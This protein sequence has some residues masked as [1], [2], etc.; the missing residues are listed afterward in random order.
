MGYLVVFDIDGTVA[1]AGGP[2]TA[3]QIQGLKEQGHSWGILSSRSPERSRQATDAMGLSPGFIR[4]CRVYQRAEELKA[5]REECPEYGRYI[6]VADAP[7]DREEAIKAGWAFIFA[8][9]FTPGA[10]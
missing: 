10:L 8:G 1:G 9:Q 7:Q 3:E 2:V 6:Y 5:L 4:S